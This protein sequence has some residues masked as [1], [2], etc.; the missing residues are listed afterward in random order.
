MGKGRIYGSWHKTGRAVDLSQKEDYIIVP[1]GSKYRLYLPATGKGDISGKE[2]SK[3][4]KPIQNKFRKKMM[5]MEF[6]D[7][8]KHLEAAGFTRIPKKGSITEWWHY[9]IVPGLTWWQAMIE[10]YDP[11]ALIKVFKKHIAAGIVSRGYLVKKGV[12]RRLLR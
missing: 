9:E 11:N 6:V 5:S 3:R 1:E 7:V 12:P 4:P 2:L 10:T 8:T